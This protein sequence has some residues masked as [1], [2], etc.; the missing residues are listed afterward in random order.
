VIGKTFGHYRVGEELA[1]EVWR[2]V[3]RAEHSPW[4]HSGDQ[5]GQE[6]AQRTLLLLFVAPTA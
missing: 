6:A 3:E 1:G 2:S 5:A 4:L